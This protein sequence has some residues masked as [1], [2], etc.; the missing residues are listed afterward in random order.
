MDSIRLAVR[1]GLLFGVAVLVGIYYFNTR[2]AADKARPG[3]SPSAQVQSAAPDQQ[4]TVLQALRNNRSDVQIEILRW[5]PPKE[6]AMIGPEQLL[7]RA[8]Y[9]VTVGQ[10]R[11]VRDG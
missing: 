8:I 11:T 4:A 6:I 2:P 7:C 10:S 1:G 3:T 9:R 5:W